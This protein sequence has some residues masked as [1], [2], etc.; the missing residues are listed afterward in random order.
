MKLKSLLLLLLL[1]LLLMARLTADDEFGMLL[2]YQSNKPVYVAITVSGNKGRAVF[3]LLEAVDFTI[4]DK[5]RKSLVAIF[6]KLKEHDGKKYG[7][8]V[9]IGFTVGK[10]SAL[11]DDALDGNQRIA[12]YRDIVKILGIEVPEGMRD[13][14]QGEGLPWIEQLKARRLTGL[15]TGAAGA[16]HAQTSL[17][18]AR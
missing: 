17:P 14:R 3:G 4:D 18:T 12:I 8:D 5:A 11:Y 6:E 16:M 15:C 13:S 10:S 9:K 7:R 1:L 2:G